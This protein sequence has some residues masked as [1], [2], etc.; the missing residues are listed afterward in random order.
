MLWGF[1]GTFSKAA[2]GLRGP[3]RHARAGFGQQRVPAGLQEPCLGL[4]LV[5]IAGNWGVSRGASQGECRRPGC[6]TCRGRRWEP[7]LIPYLGASPPLL[8]EPVPACIP[9]CLAVPS[10]ETPEGWAS[11]GWA[12]SGLRCRLRVALGM[13]PAFQ[14]E[15]PPGTCWPQGPAGPARR[16]LPAPLA[17]HLPPGSSPCCLSTF[18]W[19]RNTKGS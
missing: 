8:R 18:V 7:G 13:D 19:W 17:A 14:P 6:R 16:C 15:L 2:S 1:Y 12:S 11:S 9:P 3:S 4:W 10:P 5:R